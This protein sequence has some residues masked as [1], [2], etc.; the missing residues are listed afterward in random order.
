MT[1]EAIKDNLFTRNWIAYAEDIRYGVNCV[2]TNH[3]EHVVMLTI[4]GRVMAERVFVGV[5]SLPRI[6]EINRLRLK[7]GC[8][9]E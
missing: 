2:R 3:H 4:N 5:E 9:R 1:L 7:F 8:E 6:K